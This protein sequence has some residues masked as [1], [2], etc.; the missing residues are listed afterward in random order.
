MSNSET[1]FPEFIKLRFWEI[2]EMKQMNLSSYPLGSISSTLD[3]TIDVIEDLI[4]DD[5]FIRKSKVLEAIEEVLSLRPDMPLRSEYDDG[6][7]V[8]LG[9]I[10]KEL[11]LGDTNG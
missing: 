6:Y 10:N 9:L 1:S 7:C 11:K 2:L 4:K 5:E 3:C 8:A